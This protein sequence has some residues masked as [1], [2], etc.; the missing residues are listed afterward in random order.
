MQPHSVRLCYHTVGR[1]RRSS[2]T[3]IVERIA[4][5]M[6]RETDG[7]WKIGRGFVISYTDLSSVQIGSDSLFIFLRDPF[8]AGRELL[9]AFADSSALG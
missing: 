4:I 6:Q 9:G 5:G 1:D 3:D 7:P 8:L 2:H